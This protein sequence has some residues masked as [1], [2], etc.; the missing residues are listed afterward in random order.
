VWEVKSAVRGCFKP[1]R[2]GGSITTAQ[3]YLS[4]T[5][6]RAEHSTPY[7]FNGREVAERWRD[8]G[9]DIYTL[10]VDGTPLEACEGSCFCDTLE[11]GCNGW[12]TIS[13]ACTTTTS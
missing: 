5:K 4:G 11:D 2:Q 6:T 8:K 10:S 13:G 7:V 3:I 1:Q 9:F 12:R